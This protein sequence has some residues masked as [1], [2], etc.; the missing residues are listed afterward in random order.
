MATAYPGTLTQSGSYNNLNQLTSLSGQARTYDL[1]G[2]LTSD[3]QRSY[4]WDAENPACR[5]SISIGAGPWI[6]IQSGP[7]CVARRE[8]S[9][10]LSW[11]GLLGRGDPVPGC[12]G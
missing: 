4:S 3:G 11:S 2:N 1:N 12:W 6:S 5:M 9:P 8:G 7:L 10:R